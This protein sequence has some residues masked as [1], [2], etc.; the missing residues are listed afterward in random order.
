MILSK[1]SWINA[2]FV[3]L[4][5]AFYSF[6]FIFTS[7]H[8]EF[9]GVLSKSKTLQSDFWNGWATFIREGKMKYVGYVIISLTIII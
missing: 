5:S 6:I 4:M 1:Y 2:V 3:C 8:I 7:D 9:L